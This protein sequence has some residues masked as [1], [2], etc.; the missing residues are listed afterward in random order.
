M[1]KAFVSSLLS[2]AQEKPELVLLTGDLGYSV[3]E[4]FMQKHPSQYINAGI[5]EAD[6]V[7]MSAG[8][9]LC[10]K[11]PIAYS[12]TPFITMRPYEQVRLDVCY[13]NLPVLL[14]ASGAGLAYG[15]LGPTHHG[16]ED[17]A[18]MRALPN[19]TVLAP[20][21]PHE[22]S[23]LMPQAMA[24]RS[25]C[26]MR[27]GRGTEPEAYPEGS[28]P[29]VALGKAQQVASLGS[30]FAMFACGN[31]MKN[32]LDALSLLQKQGL[33]GSL[34]SMHTVKPLDSGL[35]LSLAK[36]MPV[37]TVEEHSI[38]GGLG[39]AVAECLSDAGVHPAGFARIALPD[40]F[41]KKIGG[42]DFLRGQCGLLPPQIAST[43][44]SALAKV[45]K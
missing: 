41:Q 16:T 31:I 8:L 26:Y 14:V 30:D 42:Q 25:P 10:G 23:G 4:P 38:V 37:F 40:S 36:K 20:C 34:Y 17:I 19:M 1:R 5:A 33:N 3:F 27:I 28:K 7:G 43:I 35:V 24:L 44:S 13:H 6:M 29:K 32:A 15:T 45:K 21:S 2:L 12:I 22:L 9:A 18:A 11:R 39:S